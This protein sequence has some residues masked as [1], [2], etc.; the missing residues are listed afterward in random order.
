MTDACSLSIARIKAAVRRSLQRHSNI[1]MCANALFGTSMT[2]NTP[3][4][5]FGR[6]VCKVS[7]HPLAILFLLL[8][9]SGCSSELRGLLQRADVLSIS[10][11]IFL[12]QLKGGPL[13]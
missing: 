8:M 7:Y 4:Y 9:S 1:C 12:F 2:G 11:H 13:T 5:T 3:F 6:K 10:I